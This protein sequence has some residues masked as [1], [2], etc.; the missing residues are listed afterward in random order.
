M[1]RQ[2][3]AYQ[4]AFASRPSVRSLDAKKFKFAATAAAAIDHRAGS[5]I[6]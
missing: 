4:F 2:C 5:A 3:E 6:I 1:A